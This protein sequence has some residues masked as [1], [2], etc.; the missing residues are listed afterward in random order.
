L[1]R[2][3]QNAFESNTQTSGPIQ[4]PIWP[5]G[6]L[7]LSGRDGTYVLS[8]APPISN[9][10][11]WSEWETRHTNPQ[12]IGHNNGFQHHALPTDD[13]TCFTGTSLESVFVLPEISSFKYN[14]GTGGGNDITGLNNTE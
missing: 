10:P 2:R 5:S 14:F 1:L 12:D 6:V 7:D 4:S 11:S 8:T 9:P 3:L 13:D